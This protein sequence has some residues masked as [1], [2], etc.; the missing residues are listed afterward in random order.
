MRHLPIQVG[1]FRPRGF[2]KISAFGLLIVPI[3]GRHGAGAI[4]VPI[5]IGHW[6]AREPA[7][8]ANL[9]VVA[10][11]A[12]N[13]YIPVTYRARMSLQHKWFFGGVRLIFGDWFHSRTPQQL[14]MIMCQNSVEE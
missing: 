11:K 5:A 8:S 2:P 10:C 4:R 9:T 3:L 13:P 14:Y 7:L 6:G 1:W 12:A